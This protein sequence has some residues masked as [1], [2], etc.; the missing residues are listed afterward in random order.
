MGASGDM[1]MSAFLELHE[2]PDKFIEKLNSLG[3]PKIR[4]KKEVEKK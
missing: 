2:N 3:I 4:F 1:L